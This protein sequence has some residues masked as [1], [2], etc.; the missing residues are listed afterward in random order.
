MGIV[1][2]PFT[3]L[4]LL[5][6][7]AGGAILANAGGYISGTYVSA[8]VVEAFATASSVLSSVGAGATAIAANPV[9]LGA[10]AIAV[11]AAGAYCYF[12]GIPAP[13]A[14]ALSKA[15]L[16]SAAKSGFAISISK[17][18][19]AL[20]L[21]GGAG[22]VSYRFYQ[23]YKK[24][25]RASSQAD[26][27]TGGEA[28]AEAVFGKTVW[29]RFGEAISSDVGG[30]VNRAVSF[31]QEAI[32]LVRAS[33]TTVADAAGITGKAAYSS[34]SRAA[35]EASSG[36]DSLIQRLRAYWIARRKI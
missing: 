4:M 32:D 9:V 23:S 20:V 13:V 5:P 3:S 30:A 33:S 21:L 24:A 34:A 17:L 15:G 10:A 18:A 14:A 27:A 8:A 22:Y 11:S 35:V 2:I 31:A 6:H 7:A 16:G 28:N 25:Q 36:L 1:A 12:Y 29:A 26:P 19:V